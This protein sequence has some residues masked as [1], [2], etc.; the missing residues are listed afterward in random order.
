MKTHFTILTL[1]SLLFATKMHSQL[2]TKEWIYEAEYAAVYG[3]K[4]IVE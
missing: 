1:L 3:E 4:V 2:K